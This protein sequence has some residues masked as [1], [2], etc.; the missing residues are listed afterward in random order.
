MKKYLQAKKINKREDEVVE[1][2]K[3]SDFQL[4]FG[5]E[6]K[7]QL[8]W[9][10]KWI[11]RWR[12]E[13]NKFLGASNTHKSVNNSLGKWIASRWD[14]DEWHF[15]FQRRLDVRSKVSTKKIFLARLCRFETSFLLCSRHSIAHRENEI[16]FA[17][18]NLTHGE[19][20]SD[21]PCMAIAASLF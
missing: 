2:E 14:D 13:W 17:K 8:K 16:Q 15:N 7:A 5:S 18:T 4:R 6:W 3:I 11:Q 21:S 10:Q 1:I 20:L 9:K 19:L 12:S